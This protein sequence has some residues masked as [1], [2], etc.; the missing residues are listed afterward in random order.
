[1]A[2]GNPRVSRWAMRNNEKRLIDEAA[3]A[4]AMFLPMAKDA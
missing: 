1:M 2:P 3:G 4:I